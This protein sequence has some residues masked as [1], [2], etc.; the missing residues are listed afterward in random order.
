MGI[1]HDAIQKR[2]AGQSRAGQGRA[3]QAI[4]KAS[5]CC[6]SCP[7]CWPDPDSDI[8]V[9]EER[10]DT[11]TSFQPPTCFNNRCQ[12]LPEEHQS[13]AHKHMDS[14]NSTVTWYSKT[15]TLLSTVLPT[16]SEGP[17]FYNLPQIWEGMSFDRFLDRIIPQFEDVLDS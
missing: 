5:P 13:S 3:G 16:D 9:N 1:K 11:F 7:F 6:F 2:R 12:A 14:D 4:I 8:I 10:T 15:F 17:A